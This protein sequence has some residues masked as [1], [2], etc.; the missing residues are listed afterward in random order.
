MC[1]INPSNIGTLRNLAF[2]FLVGVFISIISGKTYFKRTVSREE[3][4][5][6]YWTVILIYFLLGSSILMGTYLCHEDIVVPSH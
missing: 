5:A 3:E 1:K 4:P 6:S 2:L